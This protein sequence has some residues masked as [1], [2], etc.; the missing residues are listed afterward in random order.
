[1]KFYLHQVKRV[2]A[3]RKFSKAI[4]E[5]IAPQGN[6]DEPL[7]AMIFDS[8]F[9]KYRGVIAYFRI[10]NGTLRKND[11][12]L[13]YNTKGEYDANEVGILKM[14]MHPKDEIKA[15]D[16]GYIITGIKNSKEVKVGDTITHRK[17]PCQKA[18]Q[19]FEDVKP[20]VFAGMFPIE[21]EDF[22][23][24]RDALEK[25]QLNDASLIYQP[26]HPLLLVLVFDVVS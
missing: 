11:P 20:M 1:M 6:P 22:E 14:D 18:I 2:K 19:G 24:L 12:I 7:Q 10:M 13:F 17:A 21:N 4:V 25:L 23:D 9:D 8:M 3:W 5:R 15:G 26:R 16:V